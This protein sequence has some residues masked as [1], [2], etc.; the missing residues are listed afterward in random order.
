VSPTAPA[1]RLICEFY[2]PQ[3]PVPW[4]VPQTTRTGH[5]YKPVKLVSW[6]R[7][8]ATC[9]KMAMGR[10]KPYAGPVTLEFIFHLTKRAGGLPDTSNL[11]KAAEDALQGVA[12]V[13][14]RAVWRITS[15]RVIGDGDGA[16]VRV[17]A[18]EQA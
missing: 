16:L 13:N 14:D 5:A 18:E 9:C 10:G 12:I 2:V 7:S 4:K 6:Q 15:S 8:V 17:Y 11:T 3:R 1:A